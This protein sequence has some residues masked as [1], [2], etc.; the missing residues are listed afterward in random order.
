MK[1]NKQQVVTNFKQDVNDDSSNGKPASNLLVI[2]QVVHPRQDGNCQSIKLGQRLHKHVV[3]ALKQQATVRKTG[4]KSPLHVVLA[5]K[6]Q[7]IVS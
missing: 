4:T 6:Q 1:D 5:L 3:L 2:L 7:V